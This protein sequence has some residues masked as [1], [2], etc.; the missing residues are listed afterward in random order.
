MQAIMATEEVESL[1]PT[2]L[3]PTYNNKYVT[4]RNVEV[5]GNVTTVRNCGPG[6]SLVELG[7]KL[8]LS[9]KDGDTEQVRLLMS[10]GAPFTTDWLGTSP[11]HLAAQYGHVTTAEVLLRAGISRD[12]R[13]KVERTPLH[14]AAQEGNTAIVQLLLSHGADLRMT[15]LH[16]A[17]ERE[18]VDTVAVLLQHGA[19][20]HE[21]SKFDKTAFHIAL[22]NNRHDIVQLLQSLATQTSPLETVASTANQQAM[23]EATLAATQSLALELAQVPTPVQQE[24]VQT[25]T[26]GASTTETITTQSSPVERREILSPSSKKDSFR[27]EKITITPDNSPQ[28]KQQGSTTLQLLQAHGITLLPADETTLVASAVESGQTVV[29]TEAGKLALNLTQGTTA[30][31]PLRKTMS[32]GSSTAIVHRK[33][34]PIT[35]PTTPKQK[36]ITIRAGQIIGKSGPNILKRMNSVSLNVSNVNDLATITRQLE[37]ARR[38]AEQ[39]K[40]LY[41]R[42]EQ[43]AEKYKQQ[44]QSITQSK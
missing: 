3:I 23:E 16:W 29:L 13:T 43:E 7:K 44:L 15:P 12:A 4:V 31:S 10:K 2:L 22:D 19:N 38:E 9:A 37:E 11:L 25:S 27:T 40:K 36:V 42:K 30:T 14:I 28:K 35:L 41:S 17:V 8:L 18:R 39:Y 26:T 1:D 34:T 32:T 6:L 20:P 24:E 21:I 33:T 5:S